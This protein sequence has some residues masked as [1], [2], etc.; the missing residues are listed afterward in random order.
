[1]GKFS[2]LGIGLVFWVAMLWYCIPHDGHHI[3]HD[4]T[5]R[6]AALLN[7]NKIPSG[8]LSVDGRDVTLTGYAGTPE[9]SD[10]AV[11]LVAA[12]WGVR[13]VRTNILSR[14]AAPPAP[15][16]TK[17]QAH[18]AAASISGIL[19]LRNVEFYSA[20]DRLT[21]NGQRTL[22]QVAGVLERY[23]GMPVEIAGHTDS[24]GEPAQNLELSRQRAAAVKQYLVA[25]GIAA[26]NLTDVGFGQSQ[27]IASNKTSAGR[28]ANR[29]VEFHTKETK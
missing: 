1:M 29:R 22:S 14:P 11:K 27:P 26:T 25:K 9:V 18:A 5:S 16:V 15:V 4:L 13:T 23:P 10:N 19:K 21:P 20:S 7:T 24:R 12:M 2:I 8:G 6:S 3:Q 17:E 28:Q